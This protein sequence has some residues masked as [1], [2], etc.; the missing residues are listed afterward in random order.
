MWPYSG[1]ASWAA[2]LGAVGVLLGGVSKDVVGVRPVS[3]PPQ[4][5]TL[6]QR[7]A[8]ADFIFVGEGRRLFFVDK[9]YKEVPY[10]QAATMHKLK[11]AVIEVAVV[12]SL[13]PVAWTEG[14]VVLIPVA[15]WKDSAGRGGSY[16]KFLHRELAVGDGT[17]PRLRRRIHAHTPSTPAARVGPK[18]NPLDV[19][20][21]DQVIVSIEKRIASR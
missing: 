18:D 12:K 16:E 10:E 20:Y 4:F 11:A 21:L 13:F 6:D 17:S 8:A 2:A 5:V 9:Q 14:T 15:T 7:V 3:E 19:T 1:R